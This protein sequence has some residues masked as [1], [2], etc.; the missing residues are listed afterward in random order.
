MSGSK[1]CSNNCKECGSEC[2]ERRE[3][4][5]LIEESG[6]GSQINK[7]IGVVSGKG[8]VGKSLV[9]SL[10]AASIREKGIRWLFWMRIL[11]DRQSLK[12]LD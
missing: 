7:V 6:T 8:G 9:T 4:K 5:K 10:L 11:Q 2:S 12:C 1:E 3:P